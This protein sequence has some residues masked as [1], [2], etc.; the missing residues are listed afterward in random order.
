MG[1]NHRYLDCNNRE[2]YLFFIMFC[3]LNGMVDINS[4]GIKEHLK[5]EEFPVKYL[6][7][8]DGDKLIALHKTVMGIIGKLKFTSTGKL[9]T[10][11]HL[12][13]SI[14]FNLHPDIKEIGDKNI[15]NLFT[16]ID[17]HYFD[18]DEYL[19]LNSL[20]DNPKAIVVPKAS[21]LAGFM[22]KV[23]GKWKVNIIV[24]T[25]PSDPIWS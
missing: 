6:R 7:K 22:R 18:I 24:K 19:P 15:T 21:Y 23:G 11:T 25:D 9:K 1:I 10:H 2:K 13:T 20:V 14:D 4:K 12:I 3:I 8:L 5:G 17:D 16:A